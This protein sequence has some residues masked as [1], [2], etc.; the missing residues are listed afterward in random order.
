[1]AQNDQVA[2]PWFAP[3]GFQRG[4]VT[5]A[6]SVGF[7]SPAGEFVPVI[8]NQ[9]QRDVLYTNEINPIAFIPGRG[10]IVF[11]QKTLSPTTTALDRIN[12]ARLANYLKY[13]LDVLLKPYLFEQN[14]SHTQSSAKTTV[15]R[16]L[17]GLVALRA[18]NDFV[19]ICDSTNN[20]PDRIDQNQ[21]WIDI[22]IQPLKAIEFIY[23]PV[24]IEST[25]QPLQ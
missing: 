17:Q 2:Y 10:L 25:A 19:V 5:N 24:R 20:T 11:G 23:V 3:A 7:L 6:T 8:L 22:L 14:D 21:L 18:L 9:G 1:M 16:F 15:E 13:N 4:L 12:V